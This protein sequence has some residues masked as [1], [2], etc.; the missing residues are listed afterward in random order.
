MSDLNPVLF[1]ET[2]ADTLTD[3][4]MSA[5]GQSLHVS[6][7][8]DVVHPSTVDRVGAAVYGICVFHP[9]RFADLEH[10]GCALACR[11]ACDHPFADG[12]K[13]TA[14]MAAM[15]F[16]ET[17][18]RGISVS[19]DAVVAAALAAANDDIDAVMAALGLAG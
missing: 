4:I 6:R 14:I 12:N 11:L 17:Y 9:E 1:D 15:A 13:R 8:L 19:D 2:C 16:M 5:H 10:Q 3:V 7:G 18:G